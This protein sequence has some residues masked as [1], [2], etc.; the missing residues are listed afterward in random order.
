VPQVGILKKILAALGLSL[1]AGCAS[2]PPL[3]DVPDRVAPGMVSGC[4]GDGEK[5][6]HGLVKVAESLQVFQRVIGLINFR[7]GYLW[8]AENAQAMIL[9]WLRP[10][11]ILLFSSKGRV[12]GQFIPGHFGHG[13]IYLGTEEQLRAA[14]IWN[15]EWMRPHQDRI[16]EGRIFIDAVSEGVRMAD[17]EELFM[18]DAVGIFRPSYPNAAAGAEVMRRSMSRLG[19]P[20]DFAFDSTESERLFCLELIAISDPDLGLPEDHLY[21][22]T[23]IIPDRVAAMAL[24]G[25][26]RLSFVGYLEGHR[27]GWRTATAGQLAQR[28]MEAWPPHPAG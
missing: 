27:R 6:P 18:T 24:S 8:E 21:G 10:L 9:D 11:D 1:L 14:G 23:T 7:D 19:T 12:S 25:H 22:R 3:I 5:F 13:V 4:C 15:A 20:F 17:V 2:P 26:A 28:I 16:R